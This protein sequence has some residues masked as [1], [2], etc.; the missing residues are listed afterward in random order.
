MQAIIK[1]PRILNNTNKKYCKYI[2]PKQK[3]KISIKTSD[4]KI[5]A[6]IIRIPKNDKV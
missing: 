2:K 1:V 4:K 5:Q 3:I 6:I